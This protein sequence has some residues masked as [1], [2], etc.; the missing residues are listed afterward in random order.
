MFEVAAV[1]DGCG[2]QTVPRWPKTPTVCSA[3]P[4]HHRYSP[5]LLLDDPVQ[6]T[7][8]WPTPSRI[9]LLFSPK[10]F[11]FDPSPSPSQPAT[12][13]NTPQHPHNVQT[14][15]QVLEDGHCQERIFC[16]TG[17]GELE[18]ERQPA[19]SSTLTSSLLTPPVG[20]PND[21]DAYPHTLPWS[22]LSPRTR[23]PWFSAFPDERVHPLPAHLVDQTPPLPVDHRAVTHRHPP[24]LR[25]RI[26]TVPPTTTRPPWG[27]VGPLH[28]SARP[29]LPATD[30]A[31]T[32]TPSFA[33]LLETFSPYD[34]PFYAQ[35]QPFACKSRERRYQP[36]KLPPSGSHC[37]EH[38]H[39]VSHRSTRFVHQGSSICSPS[40]LKNVQ[41]NTRR[42]FT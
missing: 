39:R 37:L 19:G 35:S 4:S 6:P 22:K 42:P 12:S 36:S 11:W 28:P 16:E 34:A 8:A 32:S 18:E 23:K 27:T 7:T 5:S 31:T 14:K 41:E 29:P 2:E 33:C 3:S 26:S 20:P 15:S 9:L 1:A 21:E 25:Y 30:R 10:T 17:R 40:P 13:H 24:I 38:R